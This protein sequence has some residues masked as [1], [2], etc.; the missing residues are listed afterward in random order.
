MARWDVYIDGQGYIL[1]PEYGDKAYS[2][3][4]QDVYIGSTFQEFWQNWA[5][6]SFHGG[7]RQET[8]LSSK[9]IENNQYDK[10]EGLVLNRFGKAT[11][12]PLLTR[13]LAIQ[14]SNMPMVVTS[15]GARLILG[16]AVSPYIKIWYN[17]TWTDA[18]SVAGSGAVTD[19]LA[20]GSVLYAIRGG[21]V[22]TSSDTGLTWAEL[23]Y[24]PR[25]VT[26]ITVVAGGSGYTSAPTVEI[27]T[28][29]GDRGSGATAYAT[30]SGGKVTAITVTNGG[31]GYDDTPTVRLNGGG[32][33]GA[34]AYAVTG[35]GT[36]TSY[37]SAVSLGSV[38]QKLYVG[39]SSTGVFNHTDSKV[40]KSNGAAVSMCGYLEDLYWVEDCRLWRFNG[41]TAF[42]YDKLPSGFNAELLFPYRSV[43]FIM[44]WYREQNGYR[45]ACY[46]LWQGSENH[47]CSWGDFNADNRSYAMCG[48]D[49][50]VWFAVPGRGGC[51]RYDLTY[52]GLTSGPAW[53]GYGKIPYKAMAYVDGYF[54][55]G[56]YDNVAGTDG[57]YI[58]NLANPTS[59][60]TSGY[61]LSSEFDF[62]FPNDEKI[63]GSMAVYHRP[64]LT[65]EAIELEYSI[66][67]GE[68]WISC[69]LSDGVGTTRK[70]WT[71]PNLRFDTVKLRVTLHGPGTSTP[72][73]KKVLVRACAVSQAKWMW[74]LHLLADRVASR[75]G[76]VRR[77]Y[78][79]VQALKDSSNKQLP[80][81]FVDR[82][83]RTHTVVIKECVIDQQAV[84]R[85]TAYLYVELLEI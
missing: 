52:G 40:V 68:T 25:V 21:K 43:L 54:F 81:A 29:E 76:R 55:C 48:G 60:R 1:D 85:R 42:E 33:T 58:A 13:S 8:M 80:V 74:K 39:F 44:G 72:T 84:S 63:L 37:S 83:G 46:Y 57:V 17:K 73:L 24:T 69:G 51:D 45:A 5:M 9:D 53:G 26:S 30:V 59:Y 65:G 66:N 16:L 38:N 71:F 23:K 56:R 41:K 32:G 50:E 4:P 79:A 64:L 7:E 20:V 78:A 6:R 12:Q 82:I 75:G 10:G 28:E 70:V 61:L 47:L 18:T 19:L 62:D 77:G 27:V 3:D 11:L 67:G 14:S 22:I 15:D 31:S 34:S 35:L 2:E 49:D 36:P